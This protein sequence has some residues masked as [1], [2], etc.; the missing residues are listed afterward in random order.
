MLSI[1]QVPSGLSFVCALLTL[2]IPLAFNIVV[3]QVK[4]HGNPPWKKSNRW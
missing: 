1:G 3:K 4:K 2:V